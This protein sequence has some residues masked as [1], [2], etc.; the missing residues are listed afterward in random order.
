MC[1]FNKIMILSS[2]MQGKWLFAR[3]QEELRYNVHLGPRSSV[4]YI[5]TWMRSLGGPLSR[6]VD[7]LTTCSDATSLPPPRARLHIVA[8]VLRHRFG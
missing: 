2:R 8:A 6:S 3:V 4:A 7:D 5:N 1:G